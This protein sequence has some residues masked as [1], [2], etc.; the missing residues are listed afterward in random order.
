[1]YEVRTL[2][3][4]HYNNEM[5]YESILMVT[6]PPVNMNMVGNASSTVQPNT[7]G[8]YMTSCLHAY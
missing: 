4:V 6:L 2:I 8:K 1:M 3:T 7:F 5:Y